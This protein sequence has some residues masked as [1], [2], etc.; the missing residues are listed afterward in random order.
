MKEIEIIGIS[1]RH[2]G[3]GKN[4]KPYDFVVVAFKYADERMNG[5]NCGTC[6][7]S[8]IYVDKGLTVGSKVQGVVM[9]KDYKPHIY[10]IV[11]I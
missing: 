4:G 1:E 9:Y 7:L 10:C 8:G 5:F 3:V 2:R 11:G 6:N